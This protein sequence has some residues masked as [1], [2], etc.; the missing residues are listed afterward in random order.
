MNKVLNKLKRIF[1]KYKYEASIIVLSLLVLLVGTFAIGFLYSFL[2]VII[3]DCV[4][5]V[6]PIL[7]KMYKRHKEGKQAIIE[8]R[9]EEILIENNIENYYN[10]EETKVAEVIE[11]E[12]V[13]IIDEM[14]NVN[15][16]QENV[17][18]GGILSKIKKKF[19]KKDASKKVKT[20]VRKN[21]NKK[22]KST[23]SSKI[24]TILKV[25]LLLFILMII[26]GIIIV[27]VFLYKIVK[28]APKLNKDDF[29]S[30]E[31]S[32]ILDKDGVEITKVGS[33]MREK[34]AY[35]DL[36]DIL[37]D[38]IIATE[39]SRFFQHNGFDLPRFLK[40][41]LGQIAGRDSGGAST[42]TMQLSKNNVTDKKYNKAASGMTGIK[43]KF[44]DIYVSIFEI[45]KNYTKQEIIELYANSYYLGSG[46]YGVQQASLVYFNKDVKNL[47]LAEAAMIAGLFQAPDAYDPYMHPKAAEDRRQ[48]VLY[49][50]E[51]HGYITSEERQI[52][53]QM[54][55]SKLLVENKTTNAYQSFIDTVIQEVIDDTGFDPYMTP[56]II[57]TTMDR[58]KQEHIDTVMNNK[59]VTYG[60]ESYKWKDD[61]IQSGIVVMDVTN[62]AIV[63]VGGGR[64]KRGAKSYN[65]ATMIKNQI[66]STAKPL[67][68][69]GP[70]IEYNNVGS[71]TTIL[72]DVYAY[73]S[74]AN[75]NNFDKKYKGFL[76]YREALSQSRNVPALKVFQSVGREKVYE[77][78]KEFGLSPEVEENSI[79]EAHAIGGY[80]GESPLTMAAAYTAY[81]N[82]G[83]Y[84]EPY[85]YTKIVYRDTNEEYI[86]SEHGQKTRVVSAATSYI[87]TSMLETTA[88]SVVGSTTMNGIPIAAKS[89]T[90]DYNDA[91]K[92]QY[93]IP[94]GGV[95]DY[96]IVGYSP[97]Y[98]IAMWLGYDSAKDGYNNSTSYRR[99]LW[100]YVAKGIITKDSKSSFPK[101]N[102]VVSVR[103]EKE[104]LGDCLAS[105]FTPSDMATTELFKK[106]TAPTGVSDRFARL[107]NVT[108]LTATQSD[109]T[110]TIS[111]TPIMI[112]N[113][114]NQE[115][116]TAYFNE[117]IKDDKTREDLL[118]ARIDYNNTKM[119]TIIYNVYIKDVSGD[120]KLIGSTAG[121]SYNY[122]I[123]G[124]GNYTFV[125][126]TSYTIF[127][128]NAST[129]ASTNVSAVI[130]VINV[131][132]KGSESVTK[133]VGEPYYESGI[134]VVKNGVDVTSEANHTEI[135]KD[136]SSN[137]IS[138]IPYDVPGTYKIEYIIT[139][140][141]HTYNKTRTVI[142]Q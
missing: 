85:S 70:A 60:G 4:V 10:E 94:S 14:N 139:Y 109:K 40:A 102:D 21:E 24:K 61:K 128:D 111:W 63:A 142:Y 66:G 11:S 6:A 1:A 82:G 15:N 98:T 121:N 89:G 132:L 138:S 33:E 59:S 114:I 93:R 119:G 67:Y 126:K 29:Y 97:N 41:S 76:T 17:K 133:A 105:E 83:Y 103:I 124:G 7:I 58:K 79:H 54:P 8:E 49:L 75:I 43:R 78:V 65:Y 16:S 28:D 32:I 73:S 71:G 37:V 118:N 20:K 122:S 125:V 95:K 18:E 69:Y 23:K 47:T 5:I 19:K 92:K 88:G 31:S 113:S 137:V 27:S 46:A 108:N 116:L 117:M 56:M 115:Y 101:S 45:E 106:G 135:I 34:V 13:D 141:G 100:R 55:V 99:K 38:A 35:D 22:E 2:I 112:P 39:D 77:Y 12:N 120:L 57:Y 134:M 80:N 9:K 90:T 52:A 136:S 86:P 62:G 110:I 74:G 51:R 26:V 42:L 84:I 131:G 30:Q 64:N 91:Q 25:L 3:I 107:E 130:D 72:D 44:T 104:C 68:D 36:P 48:T 127:K 87:I 140:Q 129:G 50:M 96:W 81:A 123:S 53:L